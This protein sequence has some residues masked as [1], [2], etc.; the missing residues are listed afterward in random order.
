MV[1]RVACWSVP[2]RVGWHG[3][4]LSCDGPCWVAAVACWPVPVRARV[5][6]LRVGGH[7]PCCDMSDVKDLLICLTAWQ[8]NSFQAKLGLHKWEGSTGDPPTY[9]LFPPPVCL[10]LCSLEGQGYIALFGMF[11]LSPLGCAHP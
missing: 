3:R 4:V 7:G 10:P 1:L 6:D 5:E 9:P 11:A 8:L 2:V